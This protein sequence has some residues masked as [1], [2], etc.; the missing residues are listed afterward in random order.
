MP[1]PVF[2]NDLGGNH[3]QSNDLIPLAEVKRLASS[4]LKRKGGLSLGEP[5]FET[6]SSRA[7]FLEFKLS[8]CITRLSIP[9]F[10]C[11]PF[12]QFE[13]ECFVQQA[14]PVVALA[15][16]ERHGRNAQKSCSALRPVAM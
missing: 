2:H 11:P 13:S 9:V 10:F 14:A 5:P 8:T 1:N 3:R 12:A 7:I 16:Q 6:A 15:V 4:I